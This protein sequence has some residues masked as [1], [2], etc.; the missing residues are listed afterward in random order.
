MLPNFPIPTL[1]ADNLV[2]NTQITIEQTVSLANAKKL[3]DFTIFIYGDNSAIPTNN[4]ISLK[5]EIL[6]KISDKASV[7]EIKKTKRDVIILKTQKVETT[8]EAIAI[9]N[10]R[11]TQ[12]KTNI[13][14]NC[15]HSQF[16]MYDVDHETSLKDLYEDLWERDI[17]ATE[18]QRFTKLTENGRKPTKTVKVTQIGFDIPDR[19]LACMQS[20]R[21]ALYLPK[22]RQCSNCWLFGHSKNSCRSKTTCRICAQQHE[23]KDCINSSNPKCRLCSGDHSANDKK[24]EKYK[25]EV[26]ILEFQAEN[27]LAYDEAKRQVSSK[28][29]TYSKILNSSNDQEK[30]DSLNERLN[31]LEAKLE[32]ITS[33]EEK[34]SNIEKR[35]EKQL[36]NFEDKIEK[37]TEKL[38]NALQAVSIVS[39]KIPQ[40][41]QEST[42][43]I[44]QLANR[45][46]ER[47][48]N[49]ETQS[50]KIAKLDNNQPKITSSSITPIT[51]SQNTN[52]L[53]ESQKMEQ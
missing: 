10:I 8:R 45:T 36:K 4:P 44:R 47:S 16:L 19:V 27:H 52:Q 9:S 42:H 13:P 24:C 40:P 1:S 2:V 12:T 34:I 26:K 25:E 50:S 51:N 43:K 53:E 33:F 35:M 28:E 14:R 23:E 38:C 49:V 46:N 17:Y 15:T 48:P 7:S 20:F 21:T 32:K 11:Q 3:S 39:N 37:L 18:I 30:L 6:S 5:K 29:K 31:N 41:S 22:P